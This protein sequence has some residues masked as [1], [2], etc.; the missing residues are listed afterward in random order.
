MVSYNKLWKLLI[1]RDMKKG[2]L[3]KKASI[4][5]STM[6]KLAKIYREVRGNE[7]YG[8]GRFV[9][10]MLEEAEMNLAERLYDLNEAEITEEIVSTIEECDIPDYKAGAQAKKKPVGFV[11]A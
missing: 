6:A 1:D 9:R 10:K 7:G 5:S 11:I 4:S 2:D 8:N 3:M